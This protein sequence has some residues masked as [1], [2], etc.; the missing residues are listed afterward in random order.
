MP[1]KIAH[2]LDDE[3]GEVIEV[4]CGE[5]VSNGSVAH[6]HVDEDKVVEVEP[7]SVFKNVFSIS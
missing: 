7:V 6:L 3:E 1:E 5:I 4:E 2:L